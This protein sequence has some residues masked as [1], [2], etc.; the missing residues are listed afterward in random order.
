MFVGFGGLVERADSLT[1]WL[2][3]AGRFCRLAM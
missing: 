2:W 3:F 1:W